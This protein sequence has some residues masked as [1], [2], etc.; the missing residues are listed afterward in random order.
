MPRGTK[1]FEKTLSR[2]YET[3][4]PPLQS[5]QKDSKKTKAQEEGGIIK[6]IPRPFS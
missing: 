6:T 4:K 3:K 2:E 5:R 1:A